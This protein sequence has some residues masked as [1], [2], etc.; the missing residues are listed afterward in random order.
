[1]QLRFEHL[2]KTFGDI[3]AFD[4][5]TLTIESGE[6]FTF[7]GPPNSGK[8]TLLKVITGVEAPSSGTLT[9]GDRVITDLDPGARAIVTVTP[10]GQLDPSTHAVALLDGPPS[11]IEPSLRAS[12]VEE[13]KRLHA[14]LGMT[15]IC[16]T[17]EESEALA[18]SDRIA[19]L[20]DGTV[21]Q[22]GTPEDV[23]ER[24]ANIVVARFFGN[25]PM[26]VMP[27]ILEKDGVAVEIG[28]RALQLNGVV[29]E[30]YARD[31]FL[32]V[33]PEHVRLKRDPTAGWRGRVTRVESSH[34]RTVIEVHVDGGDLV[35][36]EDQESMYRVGDQVTVTMAPKYLHVFDAPGDRLV[37]R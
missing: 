20:K 35:A 19:V 7:A 11:Q 31:V 8:S 5:P 23:F 24:P 28:P 32:G 26:N 1:M 12:S 29:T 15:F 37:V 36:R 30:E 9:L 14:R 27:G 34:T 13:L 25:P 16:S 6:I 22:V 17:A 10:E 33:R 4:I 18:L 3:T 2:T 21:Y